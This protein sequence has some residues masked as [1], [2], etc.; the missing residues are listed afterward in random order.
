MTFDFFFCLF[1]HLI[2][3]GGHSSEEFVTIVDVPPHELFESVQERPE[4]KIGV[5]VFIVGLQDLHM[6]EDN[7]GQEGLVPDL[8]KLLA[9]WK[10][11]FWQNLF[12]LLFKLLLL[13][14]KVD[15]CLDS[16]KRGLGQVNVL[17]AFCQHDFAFKV[18]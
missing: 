14:Y 15:K 8:G 3:D 13:C 4:L 5:I 9:G 11:V 7:T 17:T 10:K 6:E 2:N 18:T 16:L 12:Q 1:D